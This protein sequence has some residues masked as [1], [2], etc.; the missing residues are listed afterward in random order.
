MGGSQNT[1]HRNRLR[2]KFELGGPDILEEHEILELLLFYCIPRRDTNK[3]AHSLISKFGSLINVLNADKDELMNAGASEKTSEYLSD[4]K[5]IFE[6]YY[7]SRCGNEA[8][9]INLEILPHLIYKNFDKKIQHLYLHCYPHH[10]NQ[11]FHLR[12]Y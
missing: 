5:N 3:I 8:K 11:F 6:L 12:F 2:H 9:Y 4:L 1:G 10:P 7:T